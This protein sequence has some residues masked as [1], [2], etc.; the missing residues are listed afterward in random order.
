MDSWSEMSP[1]TVPLLPTKPCANQYLS[2]VGASPFQPAVAYAL[3]NE[4]EWIVHQQRIL[5][6]NR[7]L[8]SHALKTA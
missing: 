8:L 7:D 6:G 3:D 4:R 1:R 5:Q 2:F